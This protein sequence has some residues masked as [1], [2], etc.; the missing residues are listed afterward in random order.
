M[1]PLGHRMKGFNVKSPHELVLEED[2][3]VEKILVEELSGLFPDFGIYSEEMPDFYRFRDDPRAKFIIDP[4]DGT[5]NY[6]FGIPEWGISVTHVSP[7]C[8]PLSSFIYLPVLDFMVF[9]LGN[10]ISTRMV[11]PVCTVDTSTS[12]RI[13]LG[14]ALVAYDN[15]FYKFGPDAIERFERLT[16]K[17]FTTRITGSAAFDTVMV[18]LGNF[19][20]RIWNKVEPYDI[21][22]AIP[23]IRGSGGVVSDFQGNDIQSLDGGQVVI[24][25]NHDISRELADVLN[26]DSVFSEKN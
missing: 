20:A 4:L 26:H 11:S 6:Y 13:T 24:S 23:I 21:A 2:L 9:C 22:A 12:S 7:E 10:G 8:V 14:E 17:T 5:H 25:C 15:Q 19:D 18:A 1:V 16:R 3:M